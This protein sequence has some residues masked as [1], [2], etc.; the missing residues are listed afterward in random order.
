MKGP[1]LAL[2]EFPHVPEV[3]LASLDLRFQVEFLLEAVHELVSL[4]VA[5]PDL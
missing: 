3:F 5:E 4:F 1:H 2:V